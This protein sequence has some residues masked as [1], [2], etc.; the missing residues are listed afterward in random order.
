M[1]KPRRALRAGASIG[2][3]SLIF[4]VAGTMAAG[5]QSKPSSCRSAPDV[6]ADTLPAARHTLHLYRCDARIDGVRNGIVIAEHVVSKRVSLY[7]GTIRTT[8]ISSIVLTMRNWPTCNAIY[9]E[10]PT[11][12][13]WSTLGIDRCSLHGADTFIVGWSA[14][15]H[16]RADPCRD[17]EPIAGFF[18]T[19]PW[20]ASRES[21]ILYGRRVCAAARFGTHRFTR[22]EVRFAL[23]NDR[24]SSR[25]RR[26]A[27]GQ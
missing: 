27:Y 14:P 3:A 11:V 25:L 19:T 26:V 22:S 21:A 2:V 12:H 5:A 10:V 6:I 18:P 16:L 9:E 15:P 7:G 17:Y 1:T 4:A 23:R 20:A 13:G 24:E 8:R